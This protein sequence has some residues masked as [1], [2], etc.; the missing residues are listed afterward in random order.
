MCHTFKLCGVVGYIYG[1]VKRPNP[2][3]DPVSA[4][5]WDFNNTYAARIIFS[6]LTALQEIHVSQDCSAHKMWDNLEAIHEVTGHP[7]IIN[8]IRLLFKCNME[9]GDDIIEHLLNLKVT[10]KQIHVLSNE[11][12]F[13][14]SDLFF[15]VIISSSLPPSWDNYTQAYIAKTQ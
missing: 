11:E 3:L 6:N 9:E 14:I 8:Y 5:N 1:D 7:T 2:A 15:K 10:F 12:E 13:R 4:D